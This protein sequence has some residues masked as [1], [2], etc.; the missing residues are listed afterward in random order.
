M[1]FLFFFEQF[2]NSNIMMNDIGFYFKD[3]KEE[4][5]HF[6]GYMPEYKD[7]R[8][9]VK[10]DKPYWAGLCDVPDGC[11]FSNAK[12]L[13]EAKIYN[14]KSLQERWNEIVIFSIAGLFCEEWMNNFN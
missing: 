5:E 10:N 11:E 13:V 2:S 6:I 14:G 8:H 9:T 3:D 7:G 1:N 12:E 4:V